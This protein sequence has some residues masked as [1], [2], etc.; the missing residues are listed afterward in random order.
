MGAI[1]YFFFFSPVYARTNLQI[2]ALS[3][4]NPAIMIENFCLSERLALG[5]YKPLRRWQS[6]KNSPAAGSRK[7][8][9]ETVKGNGKEKTHTRTHTHTAKW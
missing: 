5:F 4:I 2:L 6:T 8:E 7:W 1:S 3:F 9:G